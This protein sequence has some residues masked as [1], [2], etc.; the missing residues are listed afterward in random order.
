MSTSRSNADI[1]KFYEYQRARLNFVAD[2]YE[3]LAEQL[4]NADALTL[5]RQLQNR[6]FSESQLTTQHGFT[7]QNVEVKQLNKEFEVEDIKKETTIELQPKEN[8]QTFHP[9]PKHE[10][11][12]GDSTH[13]RFDL[14]NVDK[15]QQM[16][17]VKTEEIQENNVNM[18]VIPGLQTLLNDVTI[19]QYNVPMNDCRT[20]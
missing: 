4:R 17:V 14:T 2:Y 18:Q 5:I 9:I 20:Q 19:D 6:N 10:V 12:I 16:N 8:G 1:H 7:Q 15:N 11:F 13:D 3:N